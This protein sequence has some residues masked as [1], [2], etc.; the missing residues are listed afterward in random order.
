MFPD[1]TKCPLGSK[2][3]PEENCCFKANFNFI[4]IFWSHYVACRIIVPRPGIEP[5]PL[6]VEAWSLNHWTDREVPTILSVP[7]SHPILSLY[8]T[9][10]YLKLGHLLIFLTGLEYKLHENRA[11]SLSSTIILAFREWNASL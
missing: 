7:S 10:H 9:Y 2:I 6:E 5:T 8:S 1:N 3:I 4:I 11:F